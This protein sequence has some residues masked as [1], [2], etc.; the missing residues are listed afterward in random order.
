MVNGNSLK[1]HVDRFTDGLFSKMLADYVIV[2]I[3][4]EE[5]KNNLHQVDERCYSKY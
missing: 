2:D 3:Y 5:L 1:A 4:I